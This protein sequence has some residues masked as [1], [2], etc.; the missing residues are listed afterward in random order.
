MTLPKAIYAA[1]PGCGPWT[2]ESG[3]RGAGSGERTASPFPQAIT[4]VNRKKQFPATINSSIKK[5]NQKGKCIEKSVESKAIARPEW[6]RERDGE[7][8][9]KSGRHENRLFTSTVLCANLF[10]LLPQA[11][12]MISLFVW[13]H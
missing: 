3:E 12:C 6:D 2:A 1:G 5:E 11:S 7:R 9:L 8:G 10:L 13:S 4:A